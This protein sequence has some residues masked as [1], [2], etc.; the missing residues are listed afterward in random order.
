MWEET[1]NNSRE[2]VFFSLDT[3]HDYLAAHLNKINICNSEECE[4]HEPKS[5]LDRDLHRQ[6][7]MQ[8]LQNISQLYWDGRML[9]DISAT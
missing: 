4:S 7:L 6:N 5:R 8:T 2:V 1:I 9:E 3:E